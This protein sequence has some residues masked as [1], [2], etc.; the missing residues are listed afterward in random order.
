M[1]HYARIGHINNVVLATFFCSRLRP[2]RQ[3]GNAE[4]MCVRLITEL[5]SV[6]LHLQP[7][8]QRLRFYL[9][10]CDQSTWRK[11]CSVYL[12]S[13]VDTA[14]KSTS[15]ARMCLCLCWDCQLCVSRNTLHPSHISLATSVGTTDPHLRPTLYIACTYILSSVFT[16]PISLTLLYIKVPRSSA[17]HGT[18]VHSSLALPSTVAESANPL[19]RL[20]KYWNHPLLLFYNGASLP[21]SAL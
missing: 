10:E 19:S 6:T 4:G 15:F 1:V 3:L 17:P 20:F 5:G 2:H 8:L 12:A 21:H 7:W 16:L 13:F 18:S 9:H 14:K 11:I